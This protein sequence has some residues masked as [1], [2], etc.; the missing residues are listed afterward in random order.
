MA[1]P[2][3]TVAMRYAAPPASDPARTGARKSWSEQAQEVRR[4]VQVI[5]LVCKDPRTPW[6]ARLVAACIGKP[7]VIGGC[8]GTSQR[9]TQ[10]GIRSQAA[11]V[12]SSIP[13]EHGRINGRLIEDV[14][15]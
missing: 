12:R 10:N 1:Q 8:P 15:P 2:D 9:D 14:H 5:W 6:Y 7:Q 11:L 13:S 3:Q 4:E